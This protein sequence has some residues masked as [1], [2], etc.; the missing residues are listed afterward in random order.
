MELNRNQFFFLGLILLLMGAQFRMVGSYLLTE[1]T[2]QLLAERVSA[3]T[4]DEQYASFS[5]SLGSAS[6]REIH[7]PEWLGW[8]LISV[9]AVLVLQSLAMKRPD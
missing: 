7:P 8:C 9:G 3:T 1:D 2:T 6:Q 4:G 5:N